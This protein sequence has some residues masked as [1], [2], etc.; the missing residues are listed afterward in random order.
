MSNQWNTKHN[1]GATEVNKEKHNHA[2]LE[3]NALGFGHITQKQPSLLKIFD[4]LS[5][6]QIALLSHA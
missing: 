6:L 5:L 1:S 3:Y 2:I 4:Q